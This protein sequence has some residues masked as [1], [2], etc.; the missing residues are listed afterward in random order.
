MGGEA[1]VESDALV[2]F[3]TSQRQKLPIGS[4]TPRK[5]KQILLI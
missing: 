4:S 1:V 5:A 2:L 3:I